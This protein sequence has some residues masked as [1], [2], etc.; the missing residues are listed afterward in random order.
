MPAKM[1]PTIEQ[2][3]NRIADE[4]RSAISDSLAYGYK[5][6]FKRYSGPTGRASL[7]NRSGRL[8]GALRTKVSGRWPKIEAKVFLNPEPIYAKVH[9]GGMTIH[10][11]RAPYL[12]FRYKGR[13][14]RKKSVVIPRRPVW[15][16]AEKEVRPKI[17]RR[18]SLAIK[19]SLAAVK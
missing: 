19:R 18:F 7:T 3:A 13:W 1:S 15:A 17:E 12:V 5:A 4:L 11:K 2:L 10:A 14:V 16:T 8:R 9:E 6:V